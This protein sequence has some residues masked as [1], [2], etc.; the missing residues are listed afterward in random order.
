MMFKKQIRMGT[1]DAVR[2]FMFMKV[3]SPLQMVVSQ[4]RRP[5]EK[6][7]TSKKC[8][9]PEI[10]VDLIA[11]DGILVS[12]KLGSL[13]SFT[14]L[15][16]RVDT[17]SLYSSSTPPSVNITS[18]SHLTSSSSG[19][20]TESMKPMEKVR[21]WMQL[22]DV[23]GQQQNELR[24]VKKE[25]SKKNPCVDVDDLVGF[26]EVKTEIHFTEEQ[27][28]I[29]E[30]LKN[31]SCVRP[32][33]DS[34]QKKTAKTRDTSVNVDRKFND[35]NPE[36][37]SIVKPV[38]ELD[39]CA[40]MS[41]IVWV[42][43]LENPSKFY[44]QFPYES[45]SISCLSEEQIKAHPR[46]LLK[47]EKLISDMNIHYKDSRR[48]HLD[49]LPALGTLV[50]VK[51][52]NYWVRAMVTKDVDKN[53]NVMLFLVDD[54]R[55]LRVNVALIRELVP[56]FTV[57]PFQIKE[58]CIDRLAPLNSSCWSEKA[59]KRMVKLCNESDYLSAKIMAIVGEKMVI[60]LRSHSGSEGKSRDVGLALC[61]DQLA[62]KEKLGRD[63][64]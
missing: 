49:S 42:P 17:N 2:F 36:G 21:L 6:I 35:W 24:M 8:Q 5:R 29:L 43:Y 40:G 4:V 13:S 25:S 53:G 46:L 28:R 52:R 38:D 32:K 55:N 20:P 58:A 19:P 63:L 18:V 9:E 47:K 51:E 15:M 22:D 12:K 16:R 56:K 45:K 57:L 31:R 48:Y 23:V 61:L 30:R 37:R 26:E 27:K 62:I 3:W 64:E 50:A 44:I 10:I 1:P 54:G 33:T 60:E 59:V 34:C 39:I 14:R 11:R 7:F 41:V